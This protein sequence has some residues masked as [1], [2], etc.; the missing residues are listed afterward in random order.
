[1][2]KK[3]PQQRYDS[4]RQGLF[5][6]I[7]RLLTHRM[8]IVSV[9]IILQLALLVVMVG[10]FSTYFVQFYFVCIF[11]SIFA[12]L[13]IVGRN[14]H[15]DYKLAWTLP[16]AAFPVFGGL[17]YLL[18]GGSQLSKRSRRRMAELG[19][20]S[21]AALEG[22]V[23]PPDLFG[24]DGQAESQ[25]N[26]IRAASHCP[27][28]GNTQAV[29]FPLGED[30]WHRL[31]EE[32]DKAE[33]FI[34]LEYFII[35]AGVMWDAIL[36]RLERKAKAGVD[37]RIL[38]DDVGCLFTL[39][40]NF[41]KQMEE[42][43][44]RCGVVNPFRPVASIRLNNRDHRKICIIDG[45]TAFTG[46]INLADE[47]INA[48]VR[49]G[50]WKDTGILL[51]GAGAWNLA[52]MF[53]STWDYT[54]SEREDYDQYRPERWQKEPISAPGVIQPYEDNP[55]DQEAVGSNVYLNLISRATKYVY[56][57]TPYLI[58]D[59]P[60]VQAL[61]VAGKAGID[62]RII[63]PH[64]PDKKSVF[65]VTRANYPALL[66]AGVK[67]YEYTPGFIHAKTFVVDGQY[68]VVGT[69]NLDYRSLYHHFECAAYLYRCPCIADLERDFQQ[70]LAA[71][72]EVTPETVRK[73]KLGYRL[74]GGLM[75]FI[76]PLM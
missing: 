15:P 36:E 72:R 44:I 28:H 43:G 34:F 51:K 24:G 17:F 21:R 29:Y 35:R 38:Y 2:S 46:G 42:R 19:E 32:I 64:I 31:L 5:S 66:E 4:K 70:T 14:G 12:V 75:Q 6:R 20:L 62:V 8:P 74:L 61:I 48:E 68:A 55:L 65:E 59:Y 41:R 49:Y 30:L 3:T 56:I 39:P 22:H 45:H 26:Y 25:S 53:L 76:A 40:R 13:A 52:V 18:F 47:Y 37:V 67:I 33:H 1:M 11:I 50:H 16:I 58:L 63:T 9:L 71:C 57:T 7:A 10:W 60:M 73:E 69:I 54:C 23:A 27:P